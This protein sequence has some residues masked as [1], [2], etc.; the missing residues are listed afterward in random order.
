MQDALRI[1]YIP[2]L[3]TCLARMETIRTCSW[4]VPDLRYIV[5]CSL[6]KKF[7]WIVIA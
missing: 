6:R 2:T 3:G 5:G 7:S 1:S 4:P